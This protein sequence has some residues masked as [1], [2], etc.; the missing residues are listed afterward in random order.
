MQEL[1]NPIR[2][3]DDYYLTNFWRLVNGVTQRY[4]DLLCPDESELIAVIN[5]LSTDAQ[6]L[7]VRLLCR[8]GLDFRLDKLHYPEICD[9]KSA[10]NE[11]TETRL[12][13]TDA[14]DNWGTIGRLCT[15]AELKQLG[16]LQGTFKKD[17]LLEQLSEHPIPELPFT[18]IT[19]HDSQWLS[20][21]QLLYFNN[22]RQNLTDFVLSDL[23]LKRYE[24]YRLDKQTRLYQ[25]R[26]QIDLA[27][28]LALLN[29]Q[30]DQLPKN[31][32]WPIAHLLEQLPQHT[33]HPTLERQSQRI[34]EKLAR[35]YERRSEFEIALTNY[36]ACDSVF[37][38]ERQCRIWIKTD[39]EKALQQLQKIA[40]NPTNLNEQQF[41][42]NLYFRLARKLK[43]PAT[44]PKSVHYKRIDWPAPQIQGAPEQSA[45]LQLKTLGWQGVHCE[46]ALI[47]G[48]LTLTLWPALFADHLPGVFFHPFQHRPADLYHPDFFSKR[49]PLI[50]TLLDEINHPN[51]TRQIK[52]RFKHKY[53]LENPLFDWN[54]LPQD[55]LNIAL[56][57]VPAPIWQCIFDY[58]LFD[59]RQ[60]RA[61]MPDLFIWNETQF[62]W[63]EIKGPGDKLQNNQLLW[64]DKLNEL[65]LPVAVCYMGHQSVPSPTKITF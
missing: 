3:P 9:L 48:I 58:Q 5:Q 12:A 19:L 27:L 4:Q 64:L 7:Y 25:N 24:S 30:L 37:S 54:R 20:L 44:E 22:P 49:Q 50:N 11:L 53:G 46:N 55:V 38:R 39:P 33:E 47:N 61:G 56:E 8:K 40:C 21:F 45:L 17:R 6:K 41:A 35:E 65:K 60:T 31:G 2:L 52:S 59:L 1:N 10:L 51:W 63:L 62:G 13:T 42:S 36:Q 18:V 26:S 14:P 34:R 43:R 28:K 16:H 15:T 57:R 29:E 23:A 32:N